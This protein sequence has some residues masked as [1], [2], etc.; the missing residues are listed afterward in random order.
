MCEAA[1]ISCITMRLQ[2]AV[3][4]EERSHILRYALHA[5]SFIIMWTNMVI[6]EALLRKMLVKPSR[7]DMALEHVNVSEYITAMIKK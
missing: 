7:K 4:S 2:Q 1:C 5:H 3:C 6:K